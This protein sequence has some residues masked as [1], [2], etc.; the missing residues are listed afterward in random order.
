MTHATW[1]AMPRSSM[2]RARSSRPYP[3]VTLVEMKHIRMD[4]KC[5]GA[6]GGYKS[7]FN[8]FAVNIAAERVKEAVAT[9]AEI[10]ATA[11]PFCVVNLQQG[12]K[13]INA[14]IKV[15]DISEMLLDGHR[16]RPAHRAGPGR[17]GGEEGGAGQGHRINP[18]PSTIFSF[19][20]HLTIATNRFLG[21]LR[22]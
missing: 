22:A 5:C 14:N 4:S 16:P 19:S 13:K 7:A 9:G 15:M 3:G 2:S 11:C 21:S 17:P 1:A 12:A 8:D 20:A 10:L 18:F 6:G